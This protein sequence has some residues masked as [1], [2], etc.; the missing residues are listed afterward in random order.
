MYVGLID[1]DIELNRADIPLY[2]LCALTRGWERTFE[3]HLRTLYLQTI[4][5]TKSSLLIHST[6]TLDPN[7]H[8]SYSSN[9]KPRSCMYDP[10][11]RTPVLRN[12][13]TICARNDDTRYHQHIRN[14][15][16]V[17]RSR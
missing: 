7:R 15:D 11:L 17:S 2:L 10:H 16:K 12:E 14:G 9:N 6:L 4:I 13:Y 5:E 3:M 1:I 8:S